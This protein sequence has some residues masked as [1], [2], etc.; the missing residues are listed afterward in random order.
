MHNVC[1]LELGARKAMGLR[2]ETQ[3]ECEA[4]CFCHDRHRHKDQSIMAQAFS[5]VHTHAQYAICHI[6]YSLISF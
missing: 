4:G 6:L 1:H 2:N 5:H 3:S